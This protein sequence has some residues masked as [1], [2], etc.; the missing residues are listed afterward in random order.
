MCQ[1]VEAI[2]QQV[3]ALLL[4]HSICIQFPTPYQA[5]HS[6]LLTAVPKDLTPPGLHRHLIT[7][8][9]TGTHTHKN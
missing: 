9:H 8:T 1:R 2:A 7:Q 3:P 5:A 4:L 6:Y